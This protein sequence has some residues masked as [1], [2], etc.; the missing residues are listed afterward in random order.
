MS[1]KHR[2]GQLITH[3]TIML[4]Y[5]CSSYEG[6]KPSLLKKA[7]KY[8]QSNYQLALQIKSMW[9]V[10]CLLLS[11]HWLSTEYKLELTLSPFP[12][13]PSPCD[14]GHPKTSV[15]TQQPNYWPTPRSLQVQ[16][17]ALTGTVT[18][19]PKTITCKNYQSPW[20]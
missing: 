6:G 8:T 16:K 10:T 1:I 14:H 9:N 3:L 15:L 4:C 17:A 19:L 5:Y 12:P 18:T 7:E 20:V 11:K 13:L 2:D